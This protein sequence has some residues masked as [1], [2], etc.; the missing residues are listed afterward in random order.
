MAVALA[1]DN[2][3]FYAWTISAWNFSVFAWRNAGA[4]SAGPSRP[5]PGGPVRRHLRYV[6]ISPRAFQ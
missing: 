3:P 1:C 2:Y 5:Y 4:S 6:G